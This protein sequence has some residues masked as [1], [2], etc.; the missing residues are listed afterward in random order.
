M[1]RGQR[2]L[3]P[4]VKLRDYVMYNAINLEEPSLS[5][6]C[7]AS[8]SSET[9]QGNSL[10]PL[11]EFITDDKF[12]ASHKAFL[13]AITAGNEPRSYSQAVKDDIW[14][15]AMK[16]EV[17]AHEESGTWDIES[18]PPGKKAIACHWIYKYKYN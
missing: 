13:A 2:S 17:L 9:V 12:S 14:R 10:Y 15:G 18:L 6:H 8:S 5:L 16:H 7:S 3:Q 11:T 1:G 4:P